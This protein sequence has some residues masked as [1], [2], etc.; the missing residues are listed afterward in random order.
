MTSGF[1]KILVGKDPCRS[2]RKKPPLVEEI[3]QSRG[4]NGKAGVRR[5]KAPLLAGVS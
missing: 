3:L 5:C 1:S 4:L 2:D